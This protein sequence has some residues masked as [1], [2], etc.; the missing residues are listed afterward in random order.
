MLVARVAELPEATLED[1]EPMAESAVKARAAV[2]RAQ[3]ERLGREARVPQANIPAEAPVRAAAA[4]PDRTTVPT[5]HRSRPTA[6]AASSERATGWE[7]SKPSG[8]RSRSPR[9]VAA[10]RGGRVQ[11]TE[12]AL[13]A[14]GESSQAVEGGWA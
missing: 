9:S 14:A 7:A 8:S 11:G 5:F 12:G 6:A 13:T 1:R 3:P 4:A 10:Q 2:S